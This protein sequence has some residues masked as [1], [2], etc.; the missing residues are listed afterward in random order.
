M[1]FTKN[2]FV[3]VYCVH[4]AME[5]AVKLIIVTRRESKI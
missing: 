3:Q 4:Q 1:N 2:G 5:L